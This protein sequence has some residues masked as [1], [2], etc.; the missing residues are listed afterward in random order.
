MQ[1]IEDTGYI[2]LGRKLKKMQVQKNEVLHLVSKQMEP[3]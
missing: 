3:D 1:I 2:W